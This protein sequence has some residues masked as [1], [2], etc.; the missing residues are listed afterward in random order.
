MSAPPPPFI[1]K[2]PSF[3][4]LNL[5]IRKYTLINKNSTRIV[6]LTKDSVSYS[7]ELFF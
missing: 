1:D 2:I 6:Y 5:H 3:S 4:P 7:H